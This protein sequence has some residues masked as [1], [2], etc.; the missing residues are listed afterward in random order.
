MFLAFFDI[1][2]KFTPEGRFQ[3]KTGKNQIFMIFKLKAIRKMSITR[4]SLEFVF[5]AFWRLDQ[6]KTLL[7]S[8]IC[9]L[10]RAFSEIASR[11]KLH[12]Q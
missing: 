3:P 5:S 12:I 11:C 8:E 2:V 1:L 10:H 6:S 7:A 4:W 9:S